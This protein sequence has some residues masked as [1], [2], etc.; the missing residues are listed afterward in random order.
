MHEV[1]LRKLGKTLV[2]EGDRQRTGVIVV[3]FGFRG[4]GEI[5]IKVVEQLKHGEPGVSPESP[6]IEISAIIPVECS[7]CSVLD[8]FGVLCAEDD[9]E[10]VA[11]IASEV[12]SHRGL[13]DDSTLHERVQ[14]VGF[15]LFRSDDDVATSVFKDG[16]GAKTEPIAGEIGFSGVEELESVG[17]RGRDKG[18]VARRDNTGSPLTSLLASRGRIARGV[19]GGIDDSLRSFNSGDVVLSKN[20]VS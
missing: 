16:V 7:F 8:H 6:S 3:Q 10:G 14:E 2:A 19:G 13:F 18:I 12:K 4:R 5:L 15:L 17:S 9:L 20:S 11:T 1:L